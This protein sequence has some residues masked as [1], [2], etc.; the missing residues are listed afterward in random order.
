[1][2]QD[3]RPIILY[4]ENCPISSRMVTKTLKYGNIRFAP[5]QSS[6]GDLLLRRMSEEVRNQVVQKRTDDSKADVEDSYASIV[7]CDVNKTYVKSSAVLEIMR[8]LTSTDTGEDRAN[9]L[10][11]KH[12]KRFKLLQYLALLSYIIPNRLRDRVYD[13]VNMRKRLFGTAKTVDLKDHRYVNDSLL[14]DGDKTP[15]N[16]FQS[17]DPPTRGSR[18]KIVYP[19]SSSLSITYDDEFPN[20]LCLVGGIGTISTVDLPMRIV[21]RVERQSLGLK[22]AEDLIAWVKPEEIALL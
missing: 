10:S 7:V 14:R 13:L 2:K 9:T 20:G 16:L 11:M 17:P 22:D 12:S 18:V 21:L 15:I 8:L 5:F 6:V 4:D 3:N 19:S 1:M